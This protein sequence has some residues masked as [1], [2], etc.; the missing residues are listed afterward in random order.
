MISYGG[1]VG[2]GVLNTTGSVLTITASGPW[3]VGDFIVILAGA[4]TVATTPTTSWPMPVNSGGTQNDWLANGYMWDSG[5]GLGE[6][7]V[8]Y[9]TRITSAIPSGGTVTLTFAEN[10][11]GAVAQVL[12]YNLAA[13]AT[14]ALWTHDHFSNAPYR[15]MS[16]GGEVSLNA[17][18][19]DG[20]SYSSYLGY[21]P[22]TSEHPY[23][24]HLSVSFSAPYMGLPNANVAA[25]Y[26]LVFDNYAYPSAPTATTSATLNGNPTTSYVAQPVITNSPGSYDSSLGLV[27]AVGVFNTNSSPEHSMVAFTTPAVS[28]YVAGQYSA[29]SFI[30]GENYFGSTAT[31]FG[32]SSA[33]GSGGVV[34]ANIRSGTGS[35]SATSS[36]TGT[37]TAVMAQSSD[38]I[39]LA[40]PD[41]RFHTYDSPYHYT[42]DN[43]PL[44]D[45]FDRDIVL[46]DAIDFLN[47]NQYTVVASTNWSTLTIS[48]DLRI[49]LNKPFAYRIKAW[50]IQDQVLLASQQSTMFEDIVIGHNTYPGAVS[51]LSSWNQATRKVGASTLTW[52]YSG[53]GNNL[54]ISFAGYSGAGGYVIA[55]AERF[56]I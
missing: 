24:S 11:K 26:F 25:N 52:S 54:V 41:V 50:A 38:G 13:E 4:K 8:I 21:S 7:R 37:P 56:G 45:L 3:N 31:S 44:H 46:R 10:I 15:R 12:K 34:L 49:D 53:S 30:I 36:A 22:T 47:R 51:V 20:T 48:F 40:L 32:T 39:H 27:T 6:R 55:K 14:P 33:T 18:Q 43:K 28:P 29:L 1:I 19:V 17:P 42:E 9:S 23:G 35:A 16:S 5:P 2:S